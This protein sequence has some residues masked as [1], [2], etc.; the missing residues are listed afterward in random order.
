M[1]NNCRPTLNA[2]L[3]IWSPKEWSISSFDEAES[4]K[5]QLALDRNSLRV[6]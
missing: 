6:A 2:N 4:F 5:D 1:F 3:G